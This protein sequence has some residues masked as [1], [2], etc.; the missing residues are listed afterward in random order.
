MQTESSSNSKQ[1]KV[2]SLVCVHGTGR[3]VK[4][5]KNEARGINLVI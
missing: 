5:K 4:K 3:I 1:Q 2:K